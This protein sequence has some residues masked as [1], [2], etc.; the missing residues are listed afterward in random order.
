MLRQESFVQHVGPDQSF[1]L[2]QARQSQFCL[3]SCHSYGRM[4]TTE[5]QYAMYKVEGIIPNVYQL[6]YMPQRQ[7]I[8]R[9]RNQS[10]PKSGLYL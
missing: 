1:S 3:R 6:V 7:G 10:L 8:H 9:T 4:N 2:S 5:L